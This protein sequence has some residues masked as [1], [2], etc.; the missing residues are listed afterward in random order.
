MLVIS[1]CCNECIVL[2]SGIRNSVSRQFISIIGPYETS[3]TLLTFS[4][5]H[6]YLFAFFVLLGIDVMMILKWIFKGMGLEGMD[7]NHLAEGRDN[8]WAVI[9][10][11]M[12]LQVP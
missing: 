1:G 8:G 11:V 3:Y 4:N 12:N 9:S 2:N 5:E 10:T 7:R 6:E